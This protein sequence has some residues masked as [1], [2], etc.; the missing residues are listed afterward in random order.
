[1]SK[2]TN[3]AVW[4]EKHQRWQIKVQKDGIR[5]AFYS[6]KPGRTGQ[7]EANA[8][9]DAWL[10][11]NI[12]PTSVRTSVLLNEFLEG[13]ELRSSLS[14]Y[15]KEKYLVDSFIIPVIGTKKATNIT[16]QDLQDII[17]KAYNRPG[18]APLSKKTLSELKST[19]VSFAKFLRRK[20]V[21]SLFYDD[22]TIPAGAKTKTKRVLQPKDL[23]KLFNND[24]VTYRNKEVFDDYVYA[25]RFAILTGLRPGELIG[26]KPEDIHG[27]SIYVQRA[28]NIHGET[29]TGKNQNA[30]RKID[31][32]PLAYE[33][34]Q[35]QLDLYPDAEYIFNIQSQSTYRHRWQK[36]CESNDIMYISLYE[37][38]H[39]FVSIAKQLPEGLVKPIV[40]HSKAMDTFGVYGH[41]I[42]GDSEQTNKQLND[43]FTSLLTLKNTK[44]G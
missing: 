27:T 28:I 19:I 17:N 36:F 32:T 22:L 23:I 6:S 35:S 2:R 9:A 30:V 29:T 15:K 8:K 42:D 13:I 24:T 21:I 1:M 34:L 18:K 10:D 4:M 3:T 44:I 11:N 43:I 40:G 38:R 16:E 14:N 31:L 33:V 7:R 41:I 37:M 26:L 5:K 39:T 20:K 12:L 25:Y